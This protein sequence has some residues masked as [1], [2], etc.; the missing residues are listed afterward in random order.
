MTLPSISLPTRIDQARLKWTSLQQQHLYFAPVRHH[1]PACAYAVLSLIDSVK[2]DYIL[3]EGP[4]TFNSLIPSLT[5]KDTLPPVAIMGQ[6]EYCHHD[7]GLEER[8]KSLHS[9]YFPFCE[10]SPEWQALRGG[11]RINATTRFIDLPWA[12][13]VNNEEYSDLQSRSLQKERYLAHSQFIAQLAKQCHCRDH[14][15]VWEHLFEL[16]SIE[17]LADWQT[18]FNDIFIWCAL[19][20]LDYEPEVL[21]SEGSSQR[22]AH[23]LTHIKTIKQHEPNAKILIVTGGAHT[24]ALIEGLASSQPHSFAISSSEQKHFTKMQ[25][26]GEKEQAWQSLMQQHHD[27]LENNE[28]AK[29]PT[30]VYRNK[31][32]IAFLSS[33]AQTIREQQFD[34]PPSYLTVKLAAEQSLRLALLRE[35][36]GMGRY[37]LLDG[38]QSAFIKGSLD[39]SQNELWDEIKT[40]FSGYLLGQIPLGTAT[41]PLVN[42]TYERAKAFRFKL[43][44]TL[45]KTTKCDVY[46]NPQHRLRSRF[47]HLLAFLEIHFAHR[48]NGPDFLSGHQLDLLFEEWQYAWTPNVEGELISLSEKGSQLETIALNKL[49]AMEKQLAEQGQSRSSQSAVTLLIQAA[50]IGLHQRIPTLF[51]LLDSYIQQ[52]FRLESLTQCGH[53]LIH[54][55]RGRQY[56]DITDELT[57]ENRLHQ[58]IPQAFFC[59]EQLAQGDEQQQESNLQALLS[60]RELIEFMPSL[61]H[62]YD[63]KSDFYQ[64]LNRLDG[65]LDTVPLL[66]GAVD[67]LR[68]LGSYIDEKTLAAVLNATFSTGSSPEHAIGYFVGIMRTAPELVIRLPLLVNHLNSLLQQWDEERFIQILP[69]LRF[70]FSQLNP[71]Q[72]AELAQ[73]IANDIGLDTQALSLWQS[74]FSAKQMLEATKLNQKLQQRIKT[75][76]MISWFEAKK[77]EKGD[78]THGEA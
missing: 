68:Y 57:L 16:R 67:A 20:R 31:M 73:Y 32:G 77:T 62:Q 61:D 58:V 59:L 50:L 36:T 56:L 33:V 3:I 51:K 43:D 23:M 26:M 5:D 65:Q 22:E 39:D 64:Q 2:P 29:Q 47:L 66:K 24:L 63:Y 69:D 76:G 13:Q 74:E 78:H 46:R 53:K 41:P 18:L 8:E 28:A 72:N 14:D 40:C 6:A 52:D 60:L 54:L 21:A 17:A 70:A 38:L 1:S 45:A 37:D 71:K 34:N 19:A 9:A 10:Y 4:D 75:Q 42:E 11:L 12:A 25:K 49:L 55:W 15:D 27:K 35:H 30:Q 44:D 7:S 48:V